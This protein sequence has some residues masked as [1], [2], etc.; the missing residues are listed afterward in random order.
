MDASTVERHNELL[1]TIDVD[2]RLNGTKLGGNTVVV[3]A[4]TGEAQELIGAQYMNI[5][6][7]PENLQK[8]QLVGDPLSADLLNH[9]VVELAQGN[10]F[11][12]GP[13][14]N[15]YYDDDL[16]PHDLTEEDKRL[17]AALVAVQLVQQQKQQHSNILASELLNGKSMSPLS[18]LPNVSMDKPGMAAMVTSYIHAFDDETATQ[19][20]LLDSQNHER[21]L[22]MYQPQST[23]PQLPEIRLPPLPPL[24]KVL[25]NQSLLRNRYSERNLLETTPISDGSRIELTGQSQ[26]ELHAKSSFANNRPLK[27]NE[28]STELQIED[29]DEGDSDL[30]TESEL[31]SSRKSLPHKKR[32]PRKLKTQPNRNVH[33]KGANTLPAAKRS[34]YS[35]EICGVASINQAKFFE[36]LKAHYEPN[37]LQAT[38]STF[39]LKEPTTEQIETDKNTAEDE[40]GVLSCSLCSRTFKR[41]KTLENHMAVAHPPIEEFSEPEDM[42]EGI[43]HVVNIQATADEEDKIR[44]W[45]FNEDFPSDLCSETDKTGDMGDS[46]DFPDDEKGKKKKKLIHCPHCSRTFTHR[47]SLLYHFRSYSGRRL[48]QCDVCGKG[49]FAANALRVHM[50]MHS[51]DKPYKCEVCGRNF[52]QWGDLKYHMTSLHSNTKQYQCEFCGKDFARKYSLIVHRRIHTGEKNYVC[53]YCR[54]TFRASSYLVNHRRIHTGEK[55]YTCDVCH[56]PFR[57]KSDMKRHRNIHNKASNG[58]GAGGTARPAEASQPPAP[59]DLNVRPGDEF[60]QATD[61]P[62]TLYVWLPAP[63]E[64]SIEESILPD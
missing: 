55:P 38:S 8:V 30:E 17:A 34:A 57:V 23:S 26:E 16:L 52:R 41:Q 54:K 9:Q 61:D 15:Q 21:M 14:G 18:P 3:S 42:L 40:N 19:Q 49:F 37:L 58:G 6:R 25:S 7:M 24:K 47:N 39:E 29:I 5:H 35:C 10:E 60:R 27:G 13:V 62:N 63:S 50:R 4:D 2:N 59:L 56:K 53:E 12:P 36:H 64:E 48:H 11:V 20:Q 43:R 45:R 22:K 44:S 46:G 33:T 28:A 1:N 32:I 51:G 31:K